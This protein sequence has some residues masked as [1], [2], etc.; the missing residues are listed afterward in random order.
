VVLAREELEARPVLNGGHLE[1]VSVAVA[2]GGAVAGRWRGGS[3]G[4]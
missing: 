4:G 3:E 1:L 2:G